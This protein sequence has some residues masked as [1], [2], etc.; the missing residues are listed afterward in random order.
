MPIVE[1]QKTSQVGSFGE[2]EAAQSFYTLPF[3]HEFHNC[4][5]TSVIKNILCTLA[6][7]MSPQAI[8]YILFPACIAPAV[9]TL[10]ICIYTTYNDAILFGL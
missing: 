1:N 6:Y 10:N 8:E 9:L 5:F 7:C 3:L 4:A 2:I